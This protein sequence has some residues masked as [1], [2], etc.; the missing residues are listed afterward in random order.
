MH[1]LF[2]TAGRSPHGER[3]LKF[4][5]NRLLYCTNRRSPHGERGL[6]YDKR[7][8]AVP[9]PRGRSPHGERGLKYRAEQA[10]TH[11]GRVALLTESVD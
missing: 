2:H 6:K 1:D 8:Y 7:T 11:R 5:R 3:G 9:G 4:M 10:G